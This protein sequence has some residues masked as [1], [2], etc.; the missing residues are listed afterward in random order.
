MLM[1]M[2]TSFLILMM[3]LTLDTIE[4]KLVELGLATKEA[5]LPRPRCAL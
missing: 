5:I 1:K 2:Q 3:F 4:K